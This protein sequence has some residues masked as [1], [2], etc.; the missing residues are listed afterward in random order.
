MNAAL[1][2]LKRN[3]L[4]GPDD[5]EIPK[6]LVQKL[7][8]RA[9]QYRLICVLS[10]EEGAAGAL[11][12]EFTRMPSVALRREL[13]EVGRLLGETLSVLAEDRQQRRRELVAEVDAFY[14]DGFSP[15]RNPATPPATMSPRPSAG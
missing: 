14:L 10:M 6:N 13:A 15:A 9:G 5:A 2:S 3:L 12:L 8:L 4:P 7:R 1:R 11:L